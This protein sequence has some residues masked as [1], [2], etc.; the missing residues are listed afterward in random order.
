MEVD[1]ARPCVEGEGKP[2][3]KSV[4]TPAP[5]PGPAPFPHKPTTTQIPQNYTDIASTQRT[6]QG[7]GYRSTQKSKAR[8]AR[9]GWAGGE[10]Y[11]HGP[12]N[13]TGNSL[14]YT[15]TQPT[16]AADTQQHHNER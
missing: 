4:P 15:R 13:A 2:G 16:Q 6:G 1:T 7:K 10:H 12:P 8:K 14:P 11:T 3:T 5:A 9:I